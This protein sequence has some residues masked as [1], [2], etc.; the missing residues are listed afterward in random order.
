MGFERDDYL[1]RLVRKKEMKQSKQQQ[2]KEMWC[3]INKLSWIKGLQYKDSDGNYLFKEKLEGLEGRQRWAFE[4]VFC[5]DFP[6]LKKEWL[7][8]FLDYWNKLLSEDVKSINDYIINEK[9]T[10]YSQVKPKE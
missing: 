7:V 5:R 1:D 3:E 8:Y 4:R 10:S 6:E 2:T 9:L